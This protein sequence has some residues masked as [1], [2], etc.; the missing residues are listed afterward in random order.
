MSQIL[1][2]Y[3]TNRDCQLCLVQAC[4]MSCQMQTNRVLSRVLSHMS[5]A[6]E[7]RKGKDN[8]PFY[9]VEHFTM[10]HGVAQK[11]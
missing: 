5:D 1:M 4:H 10:S 7:Q 6:N 8:I 2:P 3:V 9:F 11:V